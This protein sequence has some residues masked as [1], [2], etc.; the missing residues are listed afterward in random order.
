MEST[1]SSKPEGWKAWKEAVEAGW[2]GEK[3]PR[4]HVELDGGEISI[5]AYHPFRT[6]ESARIHSRQPWQISVDIDSAEEVMPA[7][8]RG[9]EALGW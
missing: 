3:P 5:P 6:V 7:L 9:A 2:R 1:S 4:T 8:E